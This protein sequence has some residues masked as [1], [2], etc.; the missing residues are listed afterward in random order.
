MPLKEI[1][2]NS[3]DIKEDSN[4]FY[5]VSEIKS[6]KNANIVYY[7]KQAEQYRAT[8][9]YFKPFDDKNTS[10]EPVCYVYDNSDN[11][12]SK[13]Y[14]AEI[15][16]NLWNTGHISIYIVIDTKEIKIFN[17]RK[18]VSVDENGIHAVELTAAVRIS[19]K[20]VKLLKEKKLSSQYLDSGIFNNFYKNDF[21]ESTSPHYILLD[22]LKKIRTEILKEK[23]LAPYEAFINKL[24]VIFILLKFIEEKTDNSGERIVEFDK[25]NIWQGE[26]TFVEIVKKKD[27]IQFFEKLANKF[28]GNI[29]NLDNTENQLL[30]KLSQTHRYLL[31]G[32][33]DANLEPNTWQYVIWKRYS[34]NHL[35]IELISGIYEAFLPEKTDDIAYTPPYLVNL[36]IDECMPLSKHKEN[37]ADETFKILDP[38]C[39]SGIFIVTAFR[40]LVD[41]KI[42]NDFEKNRKWEV[43][44]VEVL[45]KILRENIYG[46]DL[47]QGAQEIAI[48]S[49]QIALC[50][51][52]TPVSIWENLRFDNLGDK[53]KNP[54]KN[55]VSEDFFDYFNETALETF[56]LVCG[57]PPF[58]DIS[59]KKC[60]DTVLHCRNYIPTSNTPAQIAFL[61]LEIAT[62]LVKKSGKLSFVLPAQFLYNQSDV[63]VSFQQKFFN[64][65]QVNQIYDFTFLKDKIFKENQIAVCS[66]N[67]QNKAPDSEHTITHIVSKRLQQAEERIYFEFDYYDY[68]YV[69]LEIATKDHF[70]WKT[71]LLGGGS[72]YFTIKRLKQEQT[73]GEYLENKKNNNNWVY[74][75]GYIKASENEKLKGETYLKNKYKKADY[76]TNFNYVANEDFTINAIKK[77]QPEKDIFFDGPRKKEIYFKPH[78]LIRKIPSLPI[79]YLDYDLRFK[80]GIIGIHAPETEIEELKNIVTRFNKNK[81]LY[82]FYMFCT[83]GRT[84][85]NF[86]FS[87][88]QKYD[89]ESLPYPKKED[90]LFLSYYETIQQEDIFNYLK[91][92]GQNTNNS[93]LNKQANYSEHLVPF[94]EV[95]KSIINKVH[96]KGDLQMRLG[97]VLETDTF[98]CMALHFGDNELDITN[99]IIKQDD[100]EENLKEL[101][102]EELGKSYKT[103]RRIQFYTTVGNDDV[104]YLIKPKQIRYWLKSIAIR[105]ADEMLGELAEEGF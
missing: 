80:N 104:V 105:D 78:V 76:I 103:I 85:V 6:I 92:A 50:R 7:L 77:T 33:F 100:L 82:K 98:Y 43:P 62:Q 96:A 94:A 93:V 8:A 11:A 5:L 36:M 67:L 81:E 69:P 74:S 72:L 16:K 47:K 95:F 27:I 2:N 45:Q 54:L 3:F 53:G 31:A 26:S 42:I 35:P 64:R 86:S 12:F 4:N 99:K 66:I 1:F 24:L 46:V 52:L 97:N 60:K 40:R 21:V 70:V 22:R 91:F 34:F 17:A 41:W 23:E 55:I 79:L 75:E 88:A 71:N 90:S 32:F 38:S 63:A 20:T 30:K 102:E 56:D 15:H 68:H 101:L 44:K 19:S 39:G 61:F 58:V 57:N 51:Y 83:S 84:G 14:I 9:V 59:S 28:N 65:Y 18:P 87:A 25:K 89:I 73:F 37:F 48:F 10:I 13:E 49:L 29:F